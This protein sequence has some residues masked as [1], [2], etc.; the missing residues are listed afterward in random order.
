MRFKV[1]LLFIPL[2]VLVNTF[3]TTKFD[4]WENRA[5]PEYCYLFN[6]LNL[7]NQYG[8]VGHYDHPGTTSQVFNAVVIKCVYS[9]SDSKTTLQVDVL[10]RPEYYLKCIGWTYVLVSDTLLFMFSLYVFKITNELKI[11]ILVQLSAFYSQAAIVNG[12]YRVSPEPILFML[13]IIF[14]YLILKLFFENKQLPKINFQFVHTDRIKHIGTICFKSLLFG[15]FMGFCLATKI[16]ALPFIIIPLFYL[17]LK[18]YIPFFF[19]LILSFLTFTFPIREHYDYF[20]R[21]IYGL[22]SHSG[23]YGSGKKSVFD[24]YE[25]LNN[26]FQILLNEKVIV[27]ILGLTI[28]FFIK[29]KKIR[30][31]KLLFSLLVLE[32]VLVLMVVKHFGFHYLTPIYPI[33]SINLLLMHHAK[34]MSNLGNKILLFMFFILCIFNFRSREI[35]RSLPK[36]NNK[37]INIYSNGCYSPFYA[38]KFGDDFSNHA[39]SKK[40][41]E[42]YGRQYF[43]NSF[44]KKF[45]DWDKEISIDSLIE[46][47]KKIYFYSSAPIF[48]ENSK[49][50]F[51]KGDYIS[52]IKN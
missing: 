46:K 42:I 35:K 11:A 17:S 48:I 49:Y 52:S 39:H 37:S 45:Y 23:I 15:S 9:L 28:L 40:L 32:I 19:A 16:N 36:I 21:W 47:N 34:V 12:F 44:T 14:S 51:I 8:N 43:F 1:I 50:N 13:S 5:D 27:F 3:F 26:T 31:N 25:V 10:K 4:F 30:N 20:F 38:L 22:S 6:G 7:A 18:Q 2:F 33:L 41:R 29:Y 24:I